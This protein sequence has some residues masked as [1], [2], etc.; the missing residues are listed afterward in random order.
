[1]DLRKANL[2]GLKMNT[3][4]PK[5]VSSTKQ[6]SGEAKDSLTGKNSTVEYTSSKS[7]KGPWGDK[8]S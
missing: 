8:H 2:K 3:S 1:M 6:L 5:H 4:Q 7:P